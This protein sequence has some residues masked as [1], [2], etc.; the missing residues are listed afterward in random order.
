MPPIEPNGSAHTA[1]PD[2]P[3]VRKQSCQ[4]TI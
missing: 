3:S 1:E 2:N 4:T